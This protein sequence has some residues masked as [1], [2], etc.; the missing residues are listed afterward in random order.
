[1][2]EPPVAA[3]AAAFLLGAACMTALAAV[4]ATVGPKSAKPALVSPPALFAVATSAPRPVVAPL[5]RVAEAPLLPPRAE[6]AQAEGP[7][8]LNTYYDFPEDPGAGADTPLYSAR[9][10]EIARVTRSF[11]DRVCVQGSG[12]LASGGTVSFATRDCACAET[13]PRTGQRICYEAL[14]PARFPHGRGA[15]GRPITPLRTVAV[16]PRVVPMG[17]TLFIP[18]L[19]GLPRPDGSRHDGCFVAEDRGLKIKGL[20]V[21]VFAGSSDTRR[22]WDASV[23]SNR[24]VHVLVGHPRCSHT[25]A[26]RR[27]RGGSRA[28]R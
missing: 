7:V 13:C 19:A 5:A 14:D 16:D 18:E 9:C 10:E 17:A 12:R 26:S 8:F 28:R 6:S 24:G 15:T 20:R 21:D 2:T 11:H 22:L 4:P 25:I 1:M 23:P 27:A 3:V